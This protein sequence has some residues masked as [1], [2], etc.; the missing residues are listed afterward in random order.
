ME[1]TSTDGVQLKCR[2]YV[3]LQTGF[4]DR[5]PSPHYLDIIIKG[6]EEHRLPEYYIEKLRKIEHNGHT[7]LVPLYDEVM[8][9][10]NHPD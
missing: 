9:R 2:S 3:L 7:G 1:V 8:S 4:A 10:H 6:A 5:R